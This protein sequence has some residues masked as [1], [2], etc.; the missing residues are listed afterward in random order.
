MSKAELLIARQETL[1]SREACGITAI[2]SKT[3]ENVSPM[4]PP[5]QHELQH[6]GYDSAGIGVWNNG[7]IDVHV[8]RGKVKEV[9]PPDF[10]FKDSDRGVGHNRYGTSG[11]ANKDDVRGSQPVVSKY[12]SRKLAL[13]YNGNLPDEV[14][15]KLKLRIPEELQDSMFDT[16]D[17]ANAIVSAEGGDWEEKIRNG[18][19]GIELAYSLTLLTDDGRVFGLRGPSGTWPLWYGET[20][21]KIIF[22][23]ET[24]V[25]KDENIKWEEVEPGELVEAT[26]TGVSKRKIFEETTPLFRCTLHD[27]YGGKEDS[28]MTKGV[29]Y[30]TF[31]REL[32]REL[33][34]EHPMADVDLIVGVPET[35]LV[36]AEGY[37]EELGRKP[38]VLI[39]KNTENKESESRGF[40]AP[41]LDKTSIIVSRK[42]KIEDKKQARDKR[43]FIQI[44]FVILII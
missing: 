40:I 7:A 2:F 26:P 15:E 28:L 42:Y 43:I 37:A 24:R 39:K 30:E 35:G 38:T 16:E 31:R 10:P 21:D 9:F 44:F 27:T 22:A 18:L 8:G 13:A 29:K 3:G 25:Y 11:G 1:A 17:I 34:R 33:A 4:I 5:L 19:N 20:E 41:D 14:R 12:G 23:S 32:G 6:R 36:M